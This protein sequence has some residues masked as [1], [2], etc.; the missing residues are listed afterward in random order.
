MS[1]AIVVLNAGSSSLKFS[2]YGVADEELNL[3]ARGQMEGLGTA[4]HFKAKDR[5]GQLLT[6]VS[7]DGS[8]T[9]FGHPQ[10]FAHLAQWVRQQ[11][12]GALSPV[13]VGHRM[14][15]GGTEFTG[16]TL[17]DAE[18]VAKLEQLVPLV[19]LHQPHNLAA[20]R[21]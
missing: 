11:Y 5:D 10:A 3:V 14:A 21:G 16:P 9:G 15:H 17:I 19:P 7:L 4:P 8:A 18:V 2:I 12:S 20:V 6:D 13:A 1:D